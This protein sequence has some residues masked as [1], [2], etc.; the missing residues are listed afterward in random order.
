MTY[1]DKIRE[2][3]KI[4]LSTLVD[5]DLT[6]DVARIPISHSTQKS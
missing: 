4:V 1:F 2:L 6:I 3:T 5:F